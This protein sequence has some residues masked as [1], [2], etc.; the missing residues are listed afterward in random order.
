MKKNETMMFEQSLPSD[1][2]FVTFGRKSEN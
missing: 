1:R 2:F